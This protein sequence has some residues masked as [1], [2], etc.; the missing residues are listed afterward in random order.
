MLFYSSFGATA[1]G[2]YTA[3]GVSGKRGRRVDENTDFRST[4]SL[5]EAA[6]SPKISLNVRKNIDFGLK[7]GLGTVT[8]AELNLAW[9][10]QHLFYNAPDL[11]T[12]RKRPPNRLRARPTTVPR[13]RAST[14]CEFPKS[15]T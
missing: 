14:A 9:C 5:P 12:A 15:A 10:W 8:P 6:R 11:Q 2:V 7:S 1:H 13:D 3:A 4:P